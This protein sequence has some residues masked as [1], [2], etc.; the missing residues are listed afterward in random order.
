MQINAQASSNSA[1]SPTGT[2]QDSAI[3][4]GGIEARLGGSSYAFADL[5]SNE[6]MSFVD[7]TAFIYRDS[8]TR[9]FSGRLQFDFGKAKFNLP[10]DL[11]ST[12]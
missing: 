2:N 7:P 12:K 1:V 11:L 8:A 9:R 10:V 5:M 3:L 6:M 4:R